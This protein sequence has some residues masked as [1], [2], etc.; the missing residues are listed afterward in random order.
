[1]DGAIA[2][3]LDALRQCSPQGLEATKSINAGPM[4]SLLANDGD[5]M[6][7]LSAR[8]F[9]SEEAREGMQAFRERRMPWWAR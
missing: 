2:R 8:L 9:A 6:M 1:M 5:A 3:Y 4:R 7:E